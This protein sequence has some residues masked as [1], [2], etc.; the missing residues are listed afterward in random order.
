MIAAN[1]KAE[2]GTAVLPT[3]ASAAYPVRV[4]LVSLVP[5]SR[6]VSPP[7]LSLGMPIPEDLA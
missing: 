3:V 7:L 1:L 6:L 2:A 5:L 4:A